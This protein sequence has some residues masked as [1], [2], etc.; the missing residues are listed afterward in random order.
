MTTADVIRRYYETFNSGDRESFLALLN[1]NIEHGLNQAAPEIGVSAFRQ[2]IQRMDRCY[3]EQVEELEIFIAEDD[4]TRGAAEFAIR[5]TY[6]ATDEGLPAAS[7]QKYFLRVGAFFD[8]QEG[9]VSRITNYYNLQ[10]WLRQI[11][12]SGTA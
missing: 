12:A 8:V 7:G 4:P 10:E 3:L 6:L 1:D 5:G 11:S 2:F 9:K